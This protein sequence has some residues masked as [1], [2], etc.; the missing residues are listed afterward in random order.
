MRQNELAR[1]YS[2]AKSCQPES[3]AALDFAFRVVLRQQGRRPIKTIGAQRARCAP[4]GKGTSGREVRGSR[5]KNKPE[6]KEDAMRISE[7][8]GGCCI[9]FRAP[10]CLRVSSMDGTLHS[11]AVSC[12]L[13]IGCAQLSAGG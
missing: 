12:S 1:H 11:K 9:L 8:S 3:G 2:F 10:R 13:T 5:G 7:K 4:E 6:A